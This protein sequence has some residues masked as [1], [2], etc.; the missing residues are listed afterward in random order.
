MCAETKRGPFSDQ[1][2]SDLPPLLDLNQN[3]RK[4]DKEQL[5][6]VGESYHYQQQDPGDR[7][8]GRPGG[9]AAGDVF[10]Q[11]GNQSQGD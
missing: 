7:L 5:L 8:L 1:Q 3:E 2:Y 6:L 4:P 9:H 11:F 10:Y